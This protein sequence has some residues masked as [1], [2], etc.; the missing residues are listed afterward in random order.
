MIG[1]Q[2]LMKLLGFKFGNAMIIENLNKYNNTQIV[3]LVN[4]DNTIRLIINEVPEKN[5]LEELKDVLV[6]PDMLITL[7]LVSNNNNSINYND[8]ECI[9]E[10]IIAIESYNRKAEL[11]SISGI[12]LFDRLKKIVIA[13]LYKKDIDLSEL[14]NI[15]TLE[16]VVLLDSNLTKKQHQIISCLKNLK[17]LK[18]KGLDANL[19]TLL[20]NV[21]QLECYNLKSAITFDSKFPNLN[22]LSIHRSGKNLAIDFLINLKHLVS[23]ELD[24]LSQIQII[25]NLDN[26]HHLRSLWLNN[27]INLRNFPKLNEFMEFIK[28][29]GNFSNLN[30]E[31]L[32]ELTPDRLPHLKRIAIDLGSDKKSNVILNRFLNICE[33]SK[34]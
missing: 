5:K 2:K 12:S 26:L 21:R 23:L 9:K 28:I 29:S 11:E 24:G 4:S 30:I 31:C 20:P 8:F 27:M 19:L 25:P 6:K 10:N 17:I 13:D 3:S 34:W 15:Y 33:L 14:K 16:E 18:I 32:S 22:N 7:V 1:L